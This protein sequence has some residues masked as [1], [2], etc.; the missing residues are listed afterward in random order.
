LVQG[1]DGLHHGCR[2][3]RLL[4]LPPLW[5]CF[6]FMC[7]FEGH[8]VGLIMNFCFVCVLLFYFRFRDHAR[9]FCLFVALWFRRI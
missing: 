4:L 8:I 3:V 7:L 5:L 1:G 6:M 2:A 9:L